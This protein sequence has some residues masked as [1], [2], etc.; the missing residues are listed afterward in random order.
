VQL[1]DLTL[2]GPGERPTQA[3]LGVLVE[4]HPTDRSG[5]QRRPT[6]EGVP[7]PA[8][9][10]A[11]LVTDQRPELGGEQRGAA[12]PVGCRRRQWAQSFALRDRVP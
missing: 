1:G 6:G 9:V 2:V 5:P 7:L 11:P 8:G 10:V 3:S 12:L 4:Q